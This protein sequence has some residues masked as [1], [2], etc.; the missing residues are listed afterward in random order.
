MKNNINKIDKMLNICGYRLRNFNRKENNPHLNEII[1]KLNEIGSLFNRYK[2]SL[3]YENP[4]VKGHYIYLN[5][6]I[7]PFTPWAINKEI[8]WHFLEMLPPLK[9]TEGGFLMSE[10]KKGSITTH[11]F[12]KGDEYFC[13]FYDIKKAA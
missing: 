7:E 10:F 11:F 8:Y 6:D 4:L 1:S 2:E 13:E 5:S 12:K 3:F 9:Y